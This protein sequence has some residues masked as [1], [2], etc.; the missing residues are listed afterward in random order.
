MVLPLAIPLLA[1]AAEAV[2]GELLAAVAGGAAAAAILSIPGDKAKD[3]EDNKADTQAMTRTRNRECKCPPERGVKVRKN[4]SMNP[5]PRRYQARITGFEY[6]I[7]T[8]E[9]GRETK[10]GWNMEWEWLGTSFDG[11]QPAQCLLQEAKGDYDQFL[12]EYGEPKFFFQGF[13][14][15]VKTVRVQAKKV[16]ANKPAKLKWYFQT[17]LT[18]EYMRSTLNK[19]AVAFVYQP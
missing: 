18:M 6:G 1:G 19:N 13:K 15:M 11:F 4:H 3:K 5:E 7:K 12:D 14:E 10:Q 8:D 16:H 2:A 17:P 9:R